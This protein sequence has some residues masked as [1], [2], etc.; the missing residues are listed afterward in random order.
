MEII[1]N[2]AKYVEEGY[3]GI[4]I[5]KIAG[6]NPTDE[7]IKESQYIHRKGNN[8]LKYKDFK[9][10]EGT[11]I[12]A[13]SAKGTEEDAAILQVRDPRGNMVWVRMRGSVQNRIEMLQRK[14]EI[15]G[16][17]VTYRYNRLTTNGIPLNP[18][19]VAIRDYE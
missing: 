15:I 4:I 16:K 12:D 17:L 13:I 19:G 8:F 9:D 14:H 5:R 11:I 1:N 7:S 2:H 10:E 18:R 6:P 3:E